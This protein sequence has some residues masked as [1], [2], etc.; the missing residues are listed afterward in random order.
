MLRK[1][2][3]L[4]CGSEA[5]AEHHCGYRGGVGWSSSGG[6]G[7]ISDFAEVA[8]AE[9]ARSDN[10]KY[11]GARGEGVIKA[12]DGSASDEEYFTRDHFD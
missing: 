5:V 4:P 11:A 9:D 2:R 3:R 10:G 6:F 7:Y 1:S 12:M 8:G